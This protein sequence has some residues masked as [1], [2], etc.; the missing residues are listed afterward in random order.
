M[1]VVDDSSYLKDE[2]YK[3]LKITYVDPIGSTVTL[4]EAVDP[5][6]QNYRLRRWNGAGYLTDAVENWVGLKD[7]IQ[8]QF[9]NGAFRAGDYWLLPARA[10]SGQLEWPWTSEEAK[11]GL[12]PHGVQHVYAPLAI[13]T[14]GAGENMKV[15]DCR[16]LWE[17][18]GKRT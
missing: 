13:I 4:D 15:H 5:N 10:V 8:I 2:G 16:H 9:T 17:Y 7:G 3:L 12:S 11:T 14:P 1:E 18:I 6:A